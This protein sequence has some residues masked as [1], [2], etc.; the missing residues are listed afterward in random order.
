MDT[1]TDAGKGLVEPKAPAPEVRDEKVVAESKTGYPESRLVSAAA[2]RD[3]CPDLDP[4]EWV[5][6]E[7]WDMS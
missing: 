5:V 2:V 4:A 1:S 3:R 6:L 7:A